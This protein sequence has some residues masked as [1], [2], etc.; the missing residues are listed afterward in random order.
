MVA[1]SIC[2]FDAILYCFTKMQFRPLYGQSIFPHVKIYVAYNYPKRNN[3]LLLVDLTP[4]NKKL[5]STFQAVS[6]GYRRSRQTT[7]P[8][9]QT[10]ENPIFALGRYSAMCDITGAR[11]CSEKIEA[12][13]H[14][15]ICLQITFDC[16]ISRKY[17]GLSARFSRRL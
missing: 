1:Q 17:A 15:R 16:R 7:A 4:P 11:G 10:I 6:I 9:S 14:L 13:S 8:R 5:D 12:Q 3:G 2:V